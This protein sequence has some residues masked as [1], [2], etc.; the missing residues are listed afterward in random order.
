MCFITMLVLLFAE[1]GTF[2]SS[3]VEVGTIVKADSQGEQ[4][5][6]VL[7]VNIT[8]HRTPCAIVSVEFTNDMKGGVEEEFDENILARTRIFP[9]GTESKGDDICDT[10]KDWKN[11]TLIEEYVKDNIVAGESCNLFG[12]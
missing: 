8:L 3:T 12:I 1:V 5:Y 6:A 9:N 7:S 4:D 2:A 11:T 10:T